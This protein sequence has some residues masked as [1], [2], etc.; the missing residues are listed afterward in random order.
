MAQDIRP[1]AESEGSKKICFPKATSSAS[2]ARD[3]FASESGSVVS[4]DPRATLGRTTVSSK[5]EA[6]N[7]GVAVL[8]VVIMLEN[9]TI[10]A[11]VFEVITDARII[12][13]IT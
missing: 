11:D 13:S 8:R 5:L 2:P 4:D 7:R 1:D 3:V 9:I 12:G 6:R 10:V